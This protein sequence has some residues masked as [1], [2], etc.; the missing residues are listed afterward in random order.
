[1][2]LFIGC[3]SKD[4]MEEVYLKNGTEL[5]EKIVELPDIELVYGA[6]N[7][8]L[9]GVAYD[10]FI[11]AGKNVVGVMTEFHKKSGDSSVKYDLEIVTKTTTERFEKIHEVSDILLFLPGGLGTYA[12]IFS[13][14]EEMRINNG[15]KI[16]LY[17]DNYFYTPI[18]RELYKLHENGF[19]DEVPADYM[20]IESDIDKI[21]EL[22]KEEIK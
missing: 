13:A 3:S 8:G 5:I 9:M 22:I 19:I 7:H 20:V 1:M 17:N 2:R 4:E 6:Y 18:I 15:K 16:I 14:I 21:V 12:E 10:N 11:K